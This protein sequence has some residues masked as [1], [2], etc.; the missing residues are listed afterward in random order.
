MKNL[1]QI[2]AKNALEAAATGYKGANDGEVVKK[3]PTMIRENGILGAAAFALETGKGYA[4]VFEAIITHLE[5]IDRL[6]S[7]P[8]SRESLRH[9]SRLEAFITGLTATDAAQLRAVTAETMAYLNYLRR[10]AGKKG[11]SQ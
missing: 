1:D 5:T 4:T 8:Q 11:A 10:F 9:E 7:P 6:P 2:R 3:V